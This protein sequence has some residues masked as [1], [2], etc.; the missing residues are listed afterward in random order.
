MLHKRPNNCSLKLL[1]RI[2]W[3]ICLPPDLLPMWVLLL[4]R[5][6]CS[7][8]SAIYPCR[9]LSCLLPYTPARPGDGEGKDQLSRK[10]WVLQPPC[11][12]RL[13]L[14]EM[15]AGQGDYELLRWWYFLYGRQWTLCKGR[16]MWPMDSSY[17]HAHTL[18]IYK[19]FCW[20]LCSETACL[21]LHFHLRNSMWLQR[22]LPRHTKPLWL[23]SG[24]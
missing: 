24:G 9:L 4:E 11:S 7:Q 1:G 22:F 6:T 16:M 19:I 8:R 12:F 23:G 15:P 10:Y 18:I 17:T 13:G 2:Y 21:S 5:K 14:F 3:H 20:G